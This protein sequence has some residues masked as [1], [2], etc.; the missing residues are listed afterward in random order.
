MYSR[1]KWTISNKYNSARKGKKKR[2]TQLK[3]QK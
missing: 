1:D 2:I 3:E